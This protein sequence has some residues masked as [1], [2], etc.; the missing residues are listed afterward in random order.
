MKQV[1]RSLLPDILILV[2]VLGGLGY[3]TVSGAVTTRA[4]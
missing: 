1:G 3:V 4:A 2:L